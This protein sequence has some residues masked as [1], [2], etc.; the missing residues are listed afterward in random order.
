MAIFVLRKLYSLFSS[1]DALSFV[2]ME[3]EYSNTA[4]SSLKYVSIYI[5]YDIRLIL[6][7]PLCWINLMYRG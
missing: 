6:Y 3:G 2:Y 5:Y 4:L 1:A 7:S